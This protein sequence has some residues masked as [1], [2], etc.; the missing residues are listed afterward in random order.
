MNNNRTTSLQEFVNEHFFNFF[1]AVLIFCV[2]LYNVI[3]FKGVDELFGLILIF[4]Y[5]FF[6]FKN[7]DWPFNKAFITVI[8][9]FLF[10]TCY[11][12][13]IH[14]NTPIAILTDLIIQMKPY[15]TFFAAYHMAAHFSNK[16]KR[17]LQQFCII[18]WF[19]LIPIGIYSLFDFLIFKKIMEHPTNYAASVT[20][21][22]LIYL[23]C[24]D[25]SKKDKLIFIIMLSLGLFSTRSKFYGFFVFASGIVL[26]LNSIEKI[27]LN[28]KTGSAFLIILLAVCFVAKNK[29]DLYFVQSLTGEEKDLLA[30]FVLYS[31]S[32]QILFQDFVPFGSGL[33]SFATHASGLYYSDIYSFYNID[34]VWG[35]SRKEFYFIADTYYPSLAQFG[36]VGVCLFILFWIF[37]I[38][39]LFL[40]LNQTNNI[41][42]FVISL[43]TIGY[44]FIENVADATYT[45]NRGFFMML[46]L[47]FLFATQNRERINHTPK[48]D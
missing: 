28:L 33:A 38:R 2:L 36:I 3:R 15:L 23:F 9:C 4:F 40:F 27:R 13:Y 46:F 43:L 29:I 47:G 30:R 39:K 18:T 10:Y 17:I 20:C 1:I 8:L 45:S 16:Q 11:S 5:C 22:S 7:K 24:S 25:Y 19:F 48:R 26:Y 32:I 31:T 35:L 42:N 44:L 14:S 12:F 6:I 41:K 21:L 37:L 34:N